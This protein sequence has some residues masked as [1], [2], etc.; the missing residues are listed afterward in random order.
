MNGS[1][2]N[3]RVS[4]GLHRL[5]LLL[6]STFFYTDLIAQNHYPSVH[7][8]GL[9]TTYVVVYNAYVEPGATATDSVDGDITDSIQITG[10]VNTSILG[11]YKVSYSV[12]NSAENSTKVARNVHVHDPIPPVIL[13][14]SNIVYVSLLGPFNLLDHVH[15]IDNYSDSIYLYKHYEIWANDLN[16]QERGVYSIVVVAVDSM[17]NQSKPFTLI[18]VIEGFI[19]VEEVINEN[20]LS[21][22]PNPANGVVTFRSLTN[23]LY[24]YDLMN[25]EG[26]LIENG[27]FRGT[28]ITKFKA[29]SYFIRFTNSS[30][31]EFSYSK[32]IV[33]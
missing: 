33:Q 21:I 27:S 26:K 5:V 24:K 9:D 16:L 13:S 19:T 1:Q 6:I 15:F 14:D 10:E 23:D 22:Y 12:T 4:I 11:V 8:K 31:G 17:G 3:S 30:N 7:L 20:A 28:Y 2:I 29:G 32:L 25:T 18:I